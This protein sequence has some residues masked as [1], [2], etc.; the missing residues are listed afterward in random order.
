[1]IAKPTAT[2]D[3][4]DDSLEGI[5]GDNLYANGALPAA[6]PISEAVSMKGYYTHPKFSLMLRRIHEGK[7]NFPEDFTDLI[8][9]FTLF[10]LYTL[11]ETFIRATNKYA[12]EEAELERRGDPELLTYSRYLNWK[13]L[14]TREAYIFLGILMLLSW[15]NPGR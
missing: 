6:P 15:Q 1:M 8:R 9:L 10:Y 4:L 3:D 14:T 12:E 11:V 5:P 2:W 7:V 13:S